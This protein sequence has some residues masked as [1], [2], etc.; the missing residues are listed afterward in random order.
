VLYEALTGRP[1]FESETHLATATMRLTKAPT[2]PGSIR[3][4]IPREL[5]GVVLRAM[6]R[7][8]EDRYETAEE[9]AAALDRAV[10]GAAPPPGRRRPEP[11]V[12]GPNRSGWFRSWTLVPLVLVV[13]AGLALGGYFLYENLAAGGGGGQ[14]DTAR[15]EPYEIVAAD[16]YDPDGDNLA[17]NP[18]LVGATHDASEETFWETEGYDEPDMDKNGVGIFFD[19][20]QPSQV[21]RIRIRTP[22][23]GWQFEV[24]G[25]ND[26]SFE[27][28]QALQ[29]ADGE[30][31]FVANADPGQ[32]VFVQL[33]PATYSHYLIWIT[34]LPETGAPHRVQIS[35]VDFFPPRG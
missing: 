29:G 27:D 9:M 35:E 18:D 13:L 5:E 17:E 14:P 3:P 10:L 7:S 25:A 34:L 30:M 12:A 8:P 20:G 26:T 15:R 1:P 21:T 16:D 28:A 4:G 19:L 33:E 6:A 11:A 2:P 22:T 32:P 23:P 24:R 31:E